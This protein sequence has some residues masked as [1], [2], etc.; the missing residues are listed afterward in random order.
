MC[1]RP[2]APVIA[3]LTLGVVV[4]ALPTSAQ[5]RIHRVYDTFTDPEEPRNLQNHPPDIRPDSTRWQWA[6]GE[7][8]TLVTDGVVK[9]YEGTSREA[10]MYYSELRDAFV[11]VDFTSASLSPHGGLLFRH[12]DSNQYFILE[13]NGPTL[14]R[15]DNGYPQYLGSGSKTVRAGETH[16]LGVRLEGPTIDVYFD[17][18]F[19]FR[20]S[21]WTYADG[22]Q[23]GFYYDAP[24]DPNASFDNFAISYLVPKPPCIYSVSPLGNNISADQFA[25]TVTVTAPPDCGWSAWS[26]AD[27]INLVDTGGMGSGTIR[28]SVENSTSS[29]SRSGTFTVADSTV[30]ITQAAVTAQPAASPSSGTPPEPG[31]AT[32]SPVPPSSGTGSPGSPGSAWGGEPIVWSA[33]VPSGKNVNSCWGNCGAA[34]SDKPNPCGG[35]SYWSN[36]WISQPQYVDDDYQVPSCA[37][38]TVITDLYRR[39]AISGRWT[40]HGRS[41]DGCRLHDNIC[42]AL[43]DNL[44]GFLGCFLAAV[45]PGSAYCSG[46]RD[47]NW[48][49]SYVLY[50]HSQQPVRTII[51]TQPCYTE[52]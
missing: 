7:G 16:R 49:Y 46:A 24:N 38:G 50:G 33:N 14:Y 27:F 45:A 48:S 10:W 3:C 42:R 22:V 12:V 29:E 41:S 2:L 30:T 25:G 44:A 1:S 17:E 47:E 35:P 5:T 18:A 15:N 9:N 20:V 51:S 6:N 39:Y 34:C 32:P 19:Q 36:V 40:Y 13:A 8:R 37:G 11:A 23:H 4:V 31:G 52:L 43:G 21:D 28:Y 26:E